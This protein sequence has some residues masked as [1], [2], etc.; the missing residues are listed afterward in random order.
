MMMYWDNERANPV[1]LPIGDARKLAAITAG[2]KRNIVV[3]IATIPDRLFFATL[4]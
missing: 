1:I 3:K 4:H 2:M